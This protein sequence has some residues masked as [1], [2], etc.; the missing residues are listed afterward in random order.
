MK[1]NM[2]SLPHETVATRPKKEVPKGQKHSNGDRK[3]KSSRLKG[4]RHV[5]SIATPR[6][7][8]PSRK[9]QIIQFLDKAEELSNANSPNVK[10]EF[11]QLFQNH[12]A[13]L[14]TKPLEKS[15]EESQNVLYKLLGNEEKYN[16]WAGLPNDHFGLKYFLKELLDKHY[17]LIEARHPNL[18]CNTLAYGLIFKRHDFVTAVLQIEN[19]NSRLFEGG[20]S[21][22]NC[23]LLALEHTSPSLQVLTQR[24]M[25]YPDI[26]DHK[27][28]DG[29][30]PI[31]EIVR[32]TG[33]EVLEE[34][35]RNVLKD[36]LPQSQ[37]QDQRIVGSPDISKGTGNELY[38]KA[39]DRSRD[40][41]DIDEG[42]SELK[43][44]EV[45]AEQTSD[46]EGAKEEN[47][48]EST[49]HENEEEWIEQASYEQ[50]SRPDDTNH[51]EAISATGAP[52][53]P[54]RK[55][56]LQ[57][58]LTAWKDGLKATNNMKRTPYQERIER[59]KNCQEFTMLLS[60]IENGNLEKVK[61]DALRK[62]VVA[63]PIAQHILAFCLREFEDRDD[64]I[65]CLYRPDDERHLDFDLAGLP[66][67]SIT[68]SFLEELKKHIRFESTLKYVALP[69]LSVEQPKTQRHIK[70]KLST[71][72]IKS[73]TD[74]RAIFA[75]LR[76]NDVKKIIKVT[77]IDYSEQPHSDT[78]IEEALHGFDV[79]VW[80]WKKMDM[81]SDV[82]SRCSRF[83]REITLYY[84]GNAA[85]LMGWSHQEA[86]GNREKFPKLRKI[87]LYV[88]QRNENTEKD[89]DRLRNSI[90]YFKEQLNNVRLGPKSLDDYVL[91]FIHGLQSENQTF[92]R[93]I[94][95]AELATEQSFLTQR[96]A[97]M[98]V[99]QQ[100]AISHTQE[101][102]QINDYPD[103]EEFHYASDFRSIAGDE[104]DSD[105]WIKC[106]DNFRRFLHG[107]S[108]AY[109]EE[110]KVSAVKI[111]IIDDGIDASE[112]SLHQAIAMGKTFSHYPNS[113]EFMNAYFVPS[114]KHGT[115]M[116][117]LITQICPNPRLF[118][119]RLDERQVPDGSGRRITVD[120]A[121]KVGR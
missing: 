78:A 4:T 16:R 114:G 55:I 111:A 97:K 103:T 3:E 14:R 99:N 119:A 120:S 48:R 90:E 8:A 6:L 5:S 81:C 75:W 53:L 121:T 108:R 41:F 101:S 27:N 57:D 62:I 83:I 105:P 56:M 89:K 32:F 18:K 37:I 92:F 45:D 84:S 52:S 25:S 30:N 93:A 44:D 59:L 43:N 91:N 31:H 116:A 94:D 115:Q 107:S 98:S 35:L 23:V 76:D 102:I 72:E 13:L 70:K 88:R 106:M 19:L 38:F 22:Y 65:K 87:N 60:T 68:Q 49:E 63:D 9:E 26:F 34:S 80:D 12:E 104:T 15:G 24:C 33:E 109:G 46:E 66:K 74:L 117:K 64:I 39:N 1:R 100:K 20:G 54:C 17:H 110:S 40:A 58:I 10:E 96:L 36:M 67:P 69:M 42:Y 11:E 51:E 28:K 85:V 7:K 118:V 50:T 82:L 61:N 112:R 113:T 29:N 79:E 21:E 95:I 2:S 86:F 71:S 77:V 47:E 73:M